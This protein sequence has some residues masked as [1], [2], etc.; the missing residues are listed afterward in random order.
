MLTTLEKLT[1]HVVV[2]TPTVKPALSSKYMVGKAALYFQNHFKNL[3]KFIRMFSFKS[4]SGNFDETMLFTVVVSASRRSSLI[5]LVVELTKEQRGCNSSL[6]RK[7]FDAA[8]RARKDLTRDIL[9]SK[10]WWLNSLWIVS[11][12]SKQDTFK[13]SLPL[14]IPMCFVMNDVLTESRWNWLFS[15]VQDG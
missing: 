4:T 3:S 7:Q 8:K 14:W 10:N 13:L 5:L 2:E 1:S 6:S 12:I 11:M 9:N 15:L